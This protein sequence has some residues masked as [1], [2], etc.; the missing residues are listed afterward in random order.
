MR[1]VAFL[2]KA[3]EDFYWWATQDRK[4]H[5]RITELIRDI[6]RQP[7]SGLGK[8]EPLK[9]ELRGLWSRRITEEH[10]LVYKVTDTEIV[11]VSSRFRYD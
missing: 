8:P 4:I 5:A 1:G 9:H 11:V 6:D 3:F 2:P 7:F 10:R